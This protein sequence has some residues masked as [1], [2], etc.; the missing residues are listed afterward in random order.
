MHGKCLL[1]RFVNS[2]F[3]WKQFF[4]WFFFVE[5]NPSDV[6][7]ELQFLKNIVYMN[8]RIKHKIV[9]INIFN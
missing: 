9:A 1:N 4:L 7:E 6:I 8:V 3:A 2:T 5:K